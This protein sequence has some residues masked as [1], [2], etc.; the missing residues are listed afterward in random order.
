MLLINKAIGM[1]LVVELCD[2]ILQCSLLLYNFIKDLQFVNRA[3]ICAM[4]PV[5]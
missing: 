3:N 5:Q 1:L 4:R 2:F